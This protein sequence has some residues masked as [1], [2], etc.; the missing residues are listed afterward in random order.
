MADKKGLAELIPQDSGYDYGNV[1]PIRR[2]KK[3]GEKELALPG[4]LSGVVNSVYDA[5]TLPGDVYSGEREATPENSLNLALLASGAGA[6]KVVRPPSVAN[7]VVRPQPGGSV[8]LGG[9][10]GEA[11]YASRN[12]SDEELK[13]V[14]STGKFYAP[15]GKDTKWWSAADDK[16]VLG[17]HWAKGKHTVRA[18]IGKV[19][20]NKPVTIA[21]TE[22]YDRAKKAWVPLS[23]H[24][25]A[26]GGAVEIDD[27]NPAKRRKLI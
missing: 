20:K 5:A 16:G 8:M 10:T 22:F 27:G 25:F 11:T 26:K 6:G 1:L 21:D 13:D 2:N 24:E 19:A 18:P 12:L 14:F 9:R 3:T 23:S 17:R 7:T 15:P 4:L